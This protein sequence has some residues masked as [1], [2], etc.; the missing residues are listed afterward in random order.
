MKAPKKPFGLSKIYR[1]IIDNFFSDSEWQSYKTKD[2]I[3]EELSDEM[4]RRILEKVQTAK[5]LELHSK[6]FRLKLVKAGKYLS[7]ACVTIVFGASIWFV[8]QKEPVELQQPVLAEKTPISQSWIEIKN[9]NDAVQQIRLPDLSLVSLFPKSSLKYE[10][11][12]S[13]KFRDVFLVGKAYFKVKRDTS[14]P[15]NVHAGGLKTTALGTSFTINTLKSANH[16][17]VVLHTGK[18]VVRQTSGKVQPIY[19]AKAGN[20]IVY[21]SENQTAQLTSNT[22]KNKPVLEPSLKRKGNALVMKNI[23]LPQ[24]IALLKESYGVAIIGIDLQHITY[25]GMVDPSK[26]QIEEVLKV[27]CLINNLNLSRGAQQEFIIQ[28][29]NQ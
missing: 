12:F 28:K 19:I 13:N 24:V 6:N 2:P 22:N 7:A 17:S 29:S 8:V 14:R 3:A 9:T 18:I 20:G 26:E 16:T 4:Y 10:K 5:Q 1:Q 15:F 27:I 11:A 25:T 23:P 21:N